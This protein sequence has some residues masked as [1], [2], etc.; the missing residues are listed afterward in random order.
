MTWF[1]PTISIVTWSRCSTSRLSASGCRTTIPPMGAQAS[2]LWSSSSCSWYCSWQG[3]RS[4]RHLMR[5]V[6]DRLSVRWYLGYNLDEPLP[7]HSSLTRI[8]TRYG[9][10]VFR[11]F[12]DVVVEQCQQ[13]G[14]V[15]GK[16]LYVDATRVQANASLDSLVTR[17]G[18]EA[19][20]AVQYHLQELFH[21]DNLSPSE[22][23]AA[24]LNVDQ[25]PVLLPTSRGED[26]PEAPRTSPASCHDWYA[27]AGEQD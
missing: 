18:V 4:E 7:D 9:L 26:E 2:I 8:R 13:A 23:A 15:W 25:L 14:L 3:I 21:Q 6:A 10:D 22:S 20:H 27:M 19:H 24:L 5:L 1:P 16:E 12:F 11:R 17:F